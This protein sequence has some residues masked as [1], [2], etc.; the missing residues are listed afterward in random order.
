MHH[1][2]LAASIAA[3]VVAFY[4][5]RM[6]IHHAVDAQSVDKIVTYGPNAGKHNFTA[7]GLRYRDIT[8]WSRLAGLIFFMAWAYLQVAR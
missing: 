6:S 5:Y 2:L 1:L 3:F 8:K 7:T 4:G